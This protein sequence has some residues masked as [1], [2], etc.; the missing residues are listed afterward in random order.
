[1][2]SVAPDEQ[3][4]ALQGCEIHMCSPDGTQLQ[5]GERVSFTITPPLAPSSDQIF[6]RI[7]VSRMECYNAMYNVPSALSFEYTIKR[8]QRTQSKPT[9]LPC[10]RG[11]MRLQMS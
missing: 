9:P 8:S 4:P 11:S 2:P 1:M 3:D 7:A 5:T 10:L 6:A